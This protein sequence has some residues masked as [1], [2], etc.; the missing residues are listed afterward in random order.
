MTTKVIGKKL[1]DTLMGEPEWEI[2]K[3]AL[4]LKLTE[5]CDQIPGNPEKCCRR[6]TPPTI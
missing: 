6:H 4:S 3:P 2:L 5:R 1:T